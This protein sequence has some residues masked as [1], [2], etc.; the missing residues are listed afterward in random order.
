MHHRTERKD[1]EKP[2][3]SRALA[4]AHHIAEPNPLAT[5]AHHGNHN[6]HAAAHHRDH[7][8]PHDAT[9]QTRKGISTALR[10]SYNRPLTELTNLRAGITSSTSAATTKAVPKDSRALSHRTPEPTRPKDT[11]ST[12]KKPL[13]KTR[14]ARPMNHA[15]W[16]GR[17][18][19]ASY[20]VQ[21]HPDGDPHHHHD[22]EHHCCQEE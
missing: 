22:G 6:P 5:A 15:R 7:Q 9:R 12:A 2:R 13:W 19:N 17:H 16:A 20:Q 14:N 10:T 18:V 3:P 21:D 8:H 11:L 1:G 4:D